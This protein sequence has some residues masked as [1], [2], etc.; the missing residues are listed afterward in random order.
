VFGKV[1]CLFNK[2]RFNV[3]FAGF[4]LNSMV[5]IQ[6]NIGYFGRYCNK[7]VNKCPMFMPHELVFLLAHHYRWI[8]VKYEKMKL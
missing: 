8:V 6:S 4:V 5:L 3:E 7:P 2:L 1:G